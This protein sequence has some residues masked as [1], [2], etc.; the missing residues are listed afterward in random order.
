MFHYPNHVLRPSVFAKYSWPHQK[1]QKGSTYEMD[2]T[3]ENVEILKQRKKC[4]EWV[5]YD[6]NVMD[7]IIQKV[8]CSPPYY[9][10]K[11]DVPVCTTTEQMKEMAS[12]IVL[13][14]DHGIEPPCKSLESMTYRYSETN[15]E[16]TPWDTV[17]DF[18]MSMTIPNP[19]FKVRRGNRNIQI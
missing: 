5:N 14:K 19:I 16:G 9:L 18:W 3:I 13:G 17:A 6:E 4:K 10:P 2:F 15:Y 8:G 12:K 7:I 1:E 11:K